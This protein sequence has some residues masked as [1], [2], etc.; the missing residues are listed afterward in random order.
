MMTGVIALLPYLFADG[1]VGW[2]VAAGEDAQVA[3]E[4]L[5][6]AMGVHGV[7]EVV[8]ADLDTSMTPKP[9]AQLLVDLAVTRS[10][11]AAS[12]QRR[13]VQRVA[14]QD[15]EVRPGLP[16]PVRLPRRRS[17]LRRGVLRLLQPRAPPHRDRVMH[18]G[19]GP[20]R[21]PPPRARW[22]RRSG[23][24]ASAAHPERFG[25]RRP[26]PPKIPTEAWIN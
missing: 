10:H 3:K 4:L 8:H 12:V 7:P 22:A 21:H 9:V 19:L 1:P 5:E 11:K 20:P 18:P 2:T 6:Q 16:Q 15:D 26:E 14:I 23:D 17:R 24:T 13:P 25:N